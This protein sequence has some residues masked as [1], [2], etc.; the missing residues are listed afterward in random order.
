[1]M[2]MSLAGARSIHDIFRQM[3]GQKERHVLAVE[4]NYNSCFECT[5]SFIL[6][7]LLRMSPKSN[8][9][10]QWI[11]SRRNCERIEGEFG[12]VNEFG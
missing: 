7:F 9:F 2:K 12:K 4:V 5:V 1:M 8:D 10:Y 3:L 6:E 11:R